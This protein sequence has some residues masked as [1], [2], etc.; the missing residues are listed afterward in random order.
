MKPCDR[1]LTEAEQQRLCE[2]FNRGLVQKRAETCSLFLP[3][4]RESKEYA[5]KRIPF[6]LV[7]RLVAHVALS[8]G[9]AW[10]R[11]LCGGLEMATCSRVWH[12]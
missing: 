6:K 1:T 4:F 8:L 11:R 10:M 9:I 7:Y 12:Q 2:A 5:R 3:H